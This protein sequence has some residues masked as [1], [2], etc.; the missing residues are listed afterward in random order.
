MALRFLFLWSGQLPDMAQH[1]TLPHAFAKH[2]AQTSV[3]RI[4]L[5]QRWSLLD[6]RPRAVNFVI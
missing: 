4:D 6:L 2:G 3:T 1:T 5:V